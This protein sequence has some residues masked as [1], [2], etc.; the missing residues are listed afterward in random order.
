M[1]EKRIIAVV[2]ATGAQGGVSQSTEPIPANLRSVARAKQEPY[3]LE[4]ITESAPT[5][6]RSPAMQFSERPAFAEA[7]SDIR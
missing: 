7:A 5:A 1:P 6:L 3:S 4:L 2:G